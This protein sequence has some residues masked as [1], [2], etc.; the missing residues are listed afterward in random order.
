MQSWCLSVGV[1][2]TCY[3]FLYDNGRG[4]IYSLFSRLYLCIFLEVSDRAVVSRY[5]TLLVLSWCLSVRGDSYMLHCYRYLNERGEPLQHGSPDVVSV[6][7]H[8]SY[9][10]HCYRYLMS[11]YR[12]FLLWWM[13][14]VLCMVGPYIIWVCNII[15]REDW[16][17]HVTLLQVSD[18]SVVKVIRCKVKAKYCL[19]EW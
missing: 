10:L 14:V 17:L 3:N 15:T 6:K 7:G 12:I 13:F 9:M 16:Q 19:R 1:T 11:V 4:I 2:A 8:D 5:K 18:L